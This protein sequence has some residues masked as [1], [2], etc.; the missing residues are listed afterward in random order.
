M[1]KYIVE[2]VNWPVL[3][4]TNDRFCKLVHLWLLFAEAVQECKGVSSEL[5]HVTYHGWS[6]SPSISNAVRAQWTLLIN[7]S[8]FPV[9]LDRPEYASVTHSFKVFLPVV[10]L[11]VIHVQLLPALGES[12][13]P[14]ARHAY[15][16]R[17][18]HHSIFLEITGQQSPQLW[19]AHHY[20]LRC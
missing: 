14:Q 4:E 9:W 20:G 16:E 2:S 8:R 15:G 12:E 7:V 11:V 6:V 1:P 10:V 5:V 17:E 13:L 18:T 3:R 19:F